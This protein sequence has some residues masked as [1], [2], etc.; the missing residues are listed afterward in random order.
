M[1]RTHMNDETI[2]LPFKSVEEKTM[3]LMHI[4]HVHI[5][6]YFFE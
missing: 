3:H 6:L 2:G 5:L 4:L 1:Q